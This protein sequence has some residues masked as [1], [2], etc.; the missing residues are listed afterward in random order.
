MIELAVVLI[1]VVV[2]AAVAVPT[3]QAVQASSLERATAASLDAVL[4]ATVAIA[5]FDG[6]LAIEPGDVQTA[7]TEAGMALSV[8]PVAGARYQV[9]ASSDG[10]YPVCGTV[11]GRSCSTAGTPTPCSTSS[12]G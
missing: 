1:V 10:A 4:R 9:C 5:R 6:R 11:P 3:Y 8:G 2:I 12:G 7:L